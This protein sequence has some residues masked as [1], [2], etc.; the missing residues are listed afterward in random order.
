M[1]KD[2]KKG[3]TG[4]FTSKAQKVHGNIYDYSR[5]M[6]DIAHHKVEILCS[7]HKSFYQTPTSH[8][9]GNGCP[10]CAIEKVRN[11][12]ISNTE[13]FVEKAKNIHRN[14][15]NYSE[16]D[17]KK[18]NIKVKIICDC[19][20]KFYQT[21]NNHLKGRGC[22]VCKYKAISIKNTKLPTGWTLTNWKKAAKKSKNFDSF[23]LYIIKCWNEDKSEVFYKIGRTFRKVNERFW[24]FPYN[25]KIINI[26]EGTAKEV[27]DL[28]IKLRQ[29]HKEYKYIPQQQF[30]GMKECYL[31][32]NFVN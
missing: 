18:S 28:E 15:Y 2:N 3:T 4:S 24:S 8:L 12:Q 1:G 29:Q 30:N 26:V 27:F 5:V 7:K 21:P 31:K 10:E 19:G 17:Y 22:T 16:V 23:K 11:K 32:I 13:K 25:Y 6:Y 20:E 14:K 9:S